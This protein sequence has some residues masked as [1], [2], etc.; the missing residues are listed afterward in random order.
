MPELTW[1][2]WLY[3]SARVALGVVTL[4]VA[5]VAA[6]N[7]RA[8]ARTL[9]RG[10]R[11][12]VV[13]T[14]LLTFQ[15][16]LSIYDGID[17]TLLHPDLPILLSAWVWFLVFNLPFP[18]IAALLIRSRRQRDALLIRLQDQS[19]TDVLTG[20]LNRRGF[21]EQAA[22]AIAQARRTGTP[23]SV[24]MLDLDRFKS[25]NDTYGHAAGDALLQAIAI[26]AR[27]GLRA[28]DLFGRLGGDE[29]GLLIVGTEAAEAAEAVD[30]LR[31]GIGGAIGALPGGD[32]VGVSAGMAPVEKRGDVTAAL[33]QA[34]SA[35]DAALYEAKRSGRGRLVT[36]NKTDRLARE[37]GA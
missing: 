4:A 2:E 3:L 24:A 23:A 15:G 28:G 31:R 9:Y 6:R 34:L 35:A 21:N 20:V 37:V 36:A 32:K 14:A 27:R 7:I 1:G 25:V 16:L 29:F 22:I 10:Y 26:A 33:D 12:F 13:V 30:R 8:T 18:L 17:N 11:D 19:V 5:W